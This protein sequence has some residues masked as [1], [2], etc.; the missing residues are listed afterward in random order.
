MFRVCSGNQP[1][2]RRQVNHSERSKLKRNPTSNAEI[3]SQKLWDQRLHDLDKFGQGFSLDNEARDI[4]GRDPHTGLGIP[5]RL[6]MIAIAAHG[7]ILRRPAKV[8]K[9]LH[10]L[11]RF[12]A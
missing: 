12:D 1:S 3:L 5:L 8:A 2:S 6:H 7:Q 9:P 4:T 10:P 11:R